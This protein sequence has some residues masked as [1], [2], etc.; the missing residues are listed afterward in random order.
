MRPCRALP[1]A[2][3]GRLA[4]IGKAGCLPFFDQPLYMSEQ[5][6]EIDQ[7]WQDLLG[8][9]VCRELGVYPLP[10]GL[11]ISVVVPVYNE[12]ATVVEIVRRIR[13]VPIPKEIILVD[14]CSTDG[15]REVLDHDRPRRG[16]SYCL[17]RAEP[18]QRGGRQDRLRPG[19]RRYRHHP[20]RRPGIRSGPVPSADPAH[21]RGHGRRG[22]RLALPARRAAPRPLFLALRW[23][24]GCSPCCRTCSPT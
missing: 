12:K 5:Y 23:A 19:H 13:E 24:I 14:D 9:I 18:R 20:G 11:R 10:E 8:K 21:R 17:A 7:K 1:G 15:T 22:L 4:N 3:I 2:I 16:P 6:S